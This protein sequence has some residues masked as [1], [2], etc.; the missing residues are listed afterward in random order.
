MKNYQH[1]DRCLNCGTPTGEKINFC[2]NC[3]QEKCK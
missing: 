1:L 3:G 2:P